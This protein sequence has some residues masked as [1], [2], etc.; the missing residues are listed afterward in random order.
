MARLIDYEQ[1]T[2]FWRQASEGGP[3]P[4]VNAALNVGRSTVSAHTYWR[5]GQ[6]DRFV[7][8]AGTLPK[9][10]AMLDLGCGPG[11]FSLELAPRLGS[12]VGIDVASAFV[13]AARAEAVRRG[14]H[15]A[16]F[17]VGSLLDALPSGPFDLVLIGSVL[18]YVDD[19]SVARLVSDLTGV[20]RPNGRVFIRV[21]CSGVGSW[22][23]TGDYAAIYRSSRWYTRV[24]RAA[25][26][27]LS[28]SEPDVFY[29]HSSLLKA[30]IQAFR[31]ITL[32]A[33][34][35]HPALE[36]ALTRL[37]IL[38][39]ALTLT[40]PFRIAMLLPTPILHSHWFVFQ[41]RSL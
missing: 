22:Q 28:L 24:C 29:T 20:L 15:H 41:R 34:R 6:I 11:L 1:V 7:Q 25:G 33:S 27:E 26:F 18:Q 8:M 14:V 31:W 30:Y 17:D 39:R 21:S 9:D 36:D 3:D 23:R 12:I 13:E 32:G 16:R 38:S 10:A 37:V 19:A 2:A 4:D 5:R 35:R 40:L